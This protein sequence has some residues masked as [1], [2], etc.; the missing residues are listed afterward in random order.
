MIHAG[1]T[2]IIK[3]LAVISHMRVDFAA[4]LNVLMGETRA[5]L[6]RL[7]HFLL[8]IYGQ[9]ESGALTAARSHMNLLDEFGDCLDVRREI[10]EAYAN[11]REALDGLDKITYEKSDANIEK[12]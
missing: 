11:W 8:E 7:Q 6:R 3:N 5:T 9:C 1:Q 4:G 12:W 10:A 2:L